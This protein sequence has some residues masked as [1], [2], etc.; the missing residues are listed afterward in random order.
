MD[1]ILPIRRLEIYRMVEA[2]RNYT[3][4]LP[5]LYGYPCYP[6]SEIPDSLNSQSLFL[7]ILEVVDITHSKS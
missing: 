3:V 4:S 7:R 5:I 1:K 2:A 6:G